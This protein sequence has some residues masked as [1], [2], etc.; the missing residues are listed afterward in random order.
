MKQKALTEALWRKK[1]R[2]ESVLLEGSG[3]LSE[4]TTAIAAD[5]FLVSIFEKRIFSFKKNETNEFL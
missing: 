1:S 2:G 3:V 5:S 4:A